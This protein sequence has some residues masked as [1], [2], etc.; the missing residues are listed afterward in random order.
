MITFV[1]LSPNTIRCVRI[2]DTA[3]CCCVFCFYISF[4]TQLATQTG[5]PHPSGSIGWYPSD[6]P[7]HAQL[8]PPVLPCSLTPTYPSSTVTVPSDPVNPPFESH[9]QL[10]LI[11]RFHSEGREHANWICC[12]SSPKHAAACSSR[13]YRASSNLA[14]RYFNYIPSLSWEFALIW[15][16]KRQSLFREHRIAPFSC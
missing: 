5:S 3:N 13:F 12:A 9:R 10:Q 16:R 8:L 14:D 11:G 15:D 4:D 2:E 6:S 1:L 7:L